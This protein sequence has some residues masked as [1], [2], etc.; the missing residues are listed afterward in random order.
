MVYLFSFDLLYQAISGK[1]GTP[2][3]R[4][5]T[6]SLMIKGILSVGMIEDNPTSS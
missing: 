2:G 1:K 3:F 6:S 4:H 5:R